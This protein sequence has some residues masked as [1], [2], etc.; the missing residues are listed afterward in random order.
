MQDTKYI[1]DYLY[2]HIPLSKAMEVEA[3]E[4]SNSKV[5]LKAP[6]PPNINHRDTV[7]GGSASTLCILSAWALVH[8]RLQSEGFTC[9]VVIQKNTMTFDKPILSEFEASCTLDEQEKWEKFTT[10]LSKKGKSRILLSS[11]LVCKGEKVGSSEGAFVA[12]VTT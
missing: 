3:V 1:Q 7:F 9:R 8:F 11:S 6:L 5:I 10:I 2:E 12:I 4:A